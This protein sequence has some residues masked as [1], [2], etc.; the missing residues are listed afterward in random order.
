[1]L[2]TDF[3]AFL[4]DCMGERGVSGSVFEKAW[5]GRCYGKAFIFAIFQ[6]MP[7]SSANAGHAPFLTRQW[8]TAIIDFF[9]FFRL[10]LFNFFPYCVL[11]NSQGCRHPRG[12]GSKISV[13]FVVLCVSRIIGG[14]RRC[15]AVAAPPFVT[16]SPPPPL[17]YQGHQRAVR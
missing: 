5:V 11:E 10:Y 4:N 13:F 7:G 17:R 2:P 12:Q 6:A 3:A 1:M 15:H 14:G 8:W 9:G 16:A